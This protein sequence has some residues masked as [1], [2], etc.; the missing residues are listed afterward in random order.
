[1]WSVASDAGGVA[2]KEIGKL[3]SKSPAELLH[4]CPVPSTCRSLFQKEKLGVFLYVAGEPK[5]LQ[6]SV[7]EK[8]WR[9]FFGSWSLPMFVIG[10]LEGH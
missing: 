4:R 1:M 7:S 3:T 9:R 5:T 6:K 10:L 2:K 8:I